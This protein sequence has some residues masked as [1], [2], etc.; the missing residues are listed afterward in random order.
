MRPQKIVLETDQRYNAVANKRHLP[1]TGM[2]FL[3]DHLVGNI[4]SVILAS[5]MIF[6]MLS[7]CISWVSSAGF[8]VSTAIPSHSIGFVPSDVPDT[9]IQLDNLMLLTKVLTRPPN[10]AVSR[11]WNYLDIKQ[12]TAW[13]WTHVA[14]FTANIGM[15][16]VVL[17]AGS[18]AFP[19]SSAR[20]SRIGSL[21][22]A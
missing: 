1:F 17:K 4:P 13:C 9:C 8:H 6:I 20:A 2:A 15:P 16:E 5:R 10:P 7:T 18:S 22:R 12:S 14:G 21:E 3:T 19:R 11:H